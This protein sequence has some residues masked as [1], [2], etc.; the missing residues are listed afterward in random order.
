[1]SKKNNLELTESHELFNDY[2]NI[3]ALNL[4]EIQITHPAELSLF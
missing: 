1:M 2:C 3:C 4:G